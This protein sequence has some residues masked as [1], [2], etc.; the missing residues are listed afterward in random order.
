MPPDK[1]ESYRCWNALSVAATGCVVTTA[2]TN[3]FTEQVA[4][5]YNPVL[6]GVNVTLT[7][8]LPGVCTTVA[9]FVNAKVPDT[10]ADPPDRIEFASVSFDEILLA[11][12]SVRI[13]VARVTLT[14]PDTSV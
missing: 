8:F 10:S 6:L 9:G 2:Y 7:V 1:L 3:T 11:V 5:V 14:R 13:S 4:V 12:G